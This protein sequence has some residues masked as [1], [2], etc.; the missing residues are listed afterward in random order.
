MAG[1]KCD[2]ERI[3]QEERTALE[4]KIALEIKIKE[5]KE[6]RVREEQKV[7][8]AADRGMMKEDLWRKVQN[9]IKAQL[10]EFQGQ[11]RAAY[12]WPPDLPDW[13]HA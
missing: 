3:A 2:A 7:R 4:E 13:P 12:F 8:K 1:V 9:Q 10:K 6:E 11:N 5:M